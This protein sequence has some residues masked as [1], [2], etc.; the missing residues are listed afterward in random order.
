MSQHQLKNPCGPNFGIKVVIELSGSENIVNFPSLSR[1]VGIA[2][3][4]HG[5][6]LGFE[7]RRGVAVQTMVVM[8]GCGD[9]CSYRLRTNEKLLL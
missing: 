6:G 3:T 1:L 8:F 2:V 4:L 5:A 9:S 7:S